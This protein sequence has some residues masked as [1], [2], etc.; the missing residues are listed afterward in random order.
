MPS[1]FSLRRT[2]DRSG[3]VVLATIGLV[4]GVLFASGRLSPIDAHGFWQAGQQA[5]YYTSTWT[6]TSICPYLYPPPFAQL[7]GILPWPVYI[8]PWTLLVFTAWWVVLRAWSMP[9]FLASLLIVTLTGYTFPLANPLLLMAIGN[10]QILIA[11]VCVIGFRWPAAWAFVLLTKIAPGVGVLWFA[12]RREWWSLGIALGVT[13]LVAV[14]SFLLAP[15]AWWE[16]ARFA[17]A[18]A[19]APSP[20]AVV[21]IPFLVRLPMSVALIIWGA[22][23]NRRWTVPIAVGWASLAL[24]EWTFITIWMAALP[25]LDDRVKARSTLVRS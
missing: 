13:V 21:P 17:L 8:I 4:L 11:A 5:H 3:L 22:R 25:L 18:N 16:Y 9:V 24:Y 7:A 12:V 1:T 19:S 20:V 10:P 23:T 2:L 15:A 6:C 14:V